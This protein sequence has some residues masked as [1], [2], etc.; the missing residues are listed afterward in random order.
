MIIYRLI[1]WIIVVDAKIRL[2]RL[3]SVHFVRIYSHLMVMVARD[4]SQPW[5]MTR[6]IVGTLKNRGLVMAK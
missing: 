3:F 5:I 2:L 6:T 4:N 1:T